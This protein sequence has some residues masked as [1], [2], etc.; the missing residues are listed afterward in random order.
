MAL[1]TR[2]SII[3]RNAKL[4]AQSALLNSGYIRIYS[5]TQPDTPE[6]GIGAGVLLAELRFGNPAFGAAANA[7]ATANAIT[8]EDA[9]LATGTAAWCRMLKSDGTTAIKD[10]SVGTSAANVVLGS[11]AIQINQVVQITSLTITE[12]MQGA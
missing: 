6:D 1:N 10:G 4:D 3:A 12:P 2:T 11:V 7:I 5:G 8:E 9:A